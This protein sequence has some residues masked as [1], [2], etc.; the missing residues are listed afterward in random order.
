MNSKYFEYI[1]VYSAVIVGCL[2]LGILA[3]MFVINMGADDFTAGIVF[4]IVVLLGI[5][6]YA[7]LTLLI[8]GLYSATVR[9]F[10]PRKKLKLPDEKSDVSDKLEKIRAE[11]QQ[12]NDKAEQD[13]KDVALRYT[14]KEFAAYCSDKDLDLLC[15]YVELYSEKKSFQDVK[16]INVEGLSNLDFYHFGWNIWKHFKVGKQE[17]VA[18]FLKSVFVNF[19]KDVETDT[20]KSHLKDDELKGIIKIRKS[21]SE[22]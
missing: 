3:R 21:L 9:W 14:Q 6:A 22:Q 5:L 13:K 16:P 2:L 4:W 20:I 18:F 8:D 10:F 7:I 1:V 15:K 12:F 11:Q 19:L 17:E